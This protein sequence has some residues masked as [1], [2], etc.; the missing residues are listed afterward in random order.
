[1]LSW[2]LVGLLASAV[3][4]CHDAPKRNPF[5]P[6]VG[7]L[8]TIEGD[9]TI[10]SQEARLRSFLFGVTESLLTA[11]SPMVEEPKRSC[12]SRRAV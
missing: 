5:D 4:G 6:D 10:E 12:L 9:I 2:T 1:M 11:R 7:S 8:H 3:I